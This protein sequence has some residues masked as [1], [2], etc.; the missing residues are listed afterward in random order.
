ML[1]IQMAKFSSDTP[2]SL[3]SGQSTRN[4]LCLS[5]ELVFEMYLFNL[6]LI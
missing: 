1:D 6:S 5:A 3:F 4:Y 2:C